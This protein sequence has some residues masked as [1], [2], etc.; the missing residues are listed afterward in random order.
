[1]AAAR[2]GALMGLVAAAALLGCAGEDP[3]APTGPTDDPP[4][5]ADDG[6]DEAPMDP[7]EWTDAIE[8]VEDAQARV[9]RDGT[10]LRVE[11]AATGD[12]SYR[13]AALRY[14]SVEELDDDTQV[15]YF[16]AMRL[17]AELLDDV[18]T[19]FSDA[20]ST[21]PDVTNGGASPTADDEPPPTPQVEG[22]VV[23]AGERAVVPRALAD[24]DLGEPTWICVQVAAVEDGEATTGES[25][26]LVGPEAGQPW[27]VACTAEAVTARDLP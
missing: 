16:L 6:A 11:V 21:T 25:A 20:D 22:V 2:R 12:T 27:H 26:L 4:N 23:A 8:Q 10:E 24:D 9:V 19:P 3:E 18:A 15:R 7:H 1:M 14:D 17:P 5:G 13:A